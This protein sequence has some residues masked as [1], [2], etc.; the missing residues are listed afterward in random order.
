MGNDL[1]KGPISKEDLITN[2]IKAKKVM[3]K[4][5]NVK[6]TN[7]IE[8]KSY[9]YD[10]MSDDEFYGKELDRQPNISKINNSKLP[11]VIKEAMIKN[12]IPS[13]NEISLSDGLD[14]TLVKKAKKLMENDGLDVTKKKTETINENNLE[15]LIERVV[16]KV[17]SENK[18]N[19]F[20]I[21]E[22]L[23]IKVGD[24][25]FKGKITSVV[26]K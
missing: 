23:V 16:R 20:N 2:L 9:D 3:N 21:E 15:K 4:V 8:N 7:I 1:K 22:N 19:E 26:K 25:L 12:P 5:D 17:L 14:L 13:V 11:N 18:T 10:D 24:S 6:T